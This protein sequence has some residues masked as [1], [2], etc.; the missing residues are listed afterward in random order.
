VRSAVWLT[1]AFLTGAWLNP[2]VAGVEVVPTPTSIATPGSS[3]A[4]PG[5]TDPAGPPA[6]SPRPTPVAAAPIVPPTCRYA[7]EPTAPDS[8]GDWTLA[9]VDTI[10]RLPAGYRPTDLVPVS[11]A[12]LTGG[13]SVRAVI[14]DDLRALG[15]AAEVAGR[16][17]AIQSA[18]RSESRQAQVYE[19]WVASHGTAEARRF[20][21]RPGHSEHQLGT[22]VDVR[23]LG[24][25]APWSTA[26]GTTKTGRWVAEHAAIYGFVLSY[27]E[28]AEA[29]T[30]YGAE[31]WHLRWVGRSVAA[32]VV[33]SGLPL[34]AWLWARNRTS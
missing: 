14:I 6:A 11:R 17:L 9:V 23:A 21:A 15:A 28:G 20:S 18:F 16:P 13:G 8:D 32:E 19:G 33:A 12:G 10:Y 4:V 27:A 34:R 24:G 26:F 22:A 25:P 5:A 30:C 29:E 1:C 7:D 31:P 2:N 3:G